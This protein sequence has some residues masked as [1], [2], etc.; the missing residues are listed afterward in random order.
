MTVEFSLPIRDERPRERFTVLLE[1]D[2][3]ITLPDFDLTW[4]DM[5]TAMGATKSNAR[6]LLDSWE[7]TPAKRVG[8]IGTMFGLKPKVIRSLAADWVEHTFDT[9]KPLDEAQ[10]DAVTYISKHLAKAMKLVRR[11]I[12]HNSP[13]MGTDQYLIEANKIAEELLWI[14]EDFPSL[15][16]GQSDIVWNVADSLKWLSYN[17]G[18][19]WRSASQIQDEWDRWLLRIATDTWKARA[20]SYSDDTSTTEWE[21]GHIAESEWQIQRF[22]GVMWAIKNKQPRPSIRGSR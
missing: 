22:H 13:A 15:L 20:C 9:I 14:R 21:E 1:R 6:L 10:K 19:G 12:Q 3:T 4:D 5:L 7:G 11:S 8:A 16:I 2:G 18:G 17:Y